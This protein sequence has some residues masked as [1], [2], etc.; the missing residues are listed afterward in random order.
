MFTFPH[1]VKILGKQVN[2]YASPRGYVKVGETIIDLT[3]KEKFTSGLNDDL[4]NQYMENL[5][6]KAVKK[7]RERMKNG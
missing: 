4:W 7:E 5:F 6:K 2:V 3:D 1:T